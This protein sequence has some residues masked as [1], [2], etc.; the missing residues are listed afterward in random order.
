MAP[1]A[2]AR[3]WIFQRLKDDPTLGA[4]IGTGSAARIYKDKAPASTQYPFV[5][6]QFVAGTYLRGVGPFRIW[7][8]MLFQIIVVT[9]G[10]STG[11]IEPIVDRIDDLLHAGSGTVTGARI[12]ECTAEGPLELPSPPEG[13]F[14]RLGNE[15][16]IKVQEF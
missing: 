13:D 15:Y 3:S 9:R 1:S 11:P 5:V 16:R 14:A 8:D 12:E 10:S 7:A 6:M 2:R 4:Q